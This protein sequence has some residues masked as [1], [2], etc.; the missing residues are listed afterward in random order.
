MQETQ[1]SNTTKAIVW[2]VA[3]LVAIV[4]VC[5]WVGWPFLRIPFTHFLEKQL[6]RTVVIDA[7]FSLHAWG[8]LRLQA[9]HVRMSAPASFQQPYFFDAHGVE[10][11]LRYRDVWQLP[12]GAA[13]RVKAIRAMQLDAHMVR[14]IDGKATWQFDLDDNS[15]TRPFPVIEGLNVRQGQVNVQDAMTGAAVLAKFTTEEGS[16]DASPHAKV[17][18]QG[19]L[20]KVPLRGMLETAGFLPAV[21]QKPDS[22]PVHSS[23]WL[24]YGALS[25][26][27]DGSVYDMFGQPRVKGRLDLVGP[28]LGDVGDLFDITLPRTSAFKVRADI[29]KSSAQ[30][31]VTVP[32]AKIG[33]SALAGKFTY[34]TEGDK[35][36]L[37]GTLTGKK[38][39]LADLAPAFGAPVAEPAS[40]KEH[41]TATSASPPA[42]MFPDTPLDFATYVRMHAEVEVDLDNVD[43]GNAFREPIAPLK[44][45]LSL[46]NNKLSLS[47]IDA[48]TAQGSL[49]GEIFIDAHEVSA[50]QA[51]GAQALVP[52]WGIELA[53]RDIRLEKWL[54]VAPTP[55]QDARTQPDTPGKPSADTPQPYISGLLNGRSRLHGQ[56]RSTRALMQS[57]N[58]ELALLIRQGKV[59]HL[60]I[61]AAGLDIAQ[62]V[63]V[64]IKGDQPLEMQCA[65]MGWK[66]KQGILTPEAALI[67]TKVTTL[68]ATG[69]VDLGQEQLDLT[70]RARPKNFSPLTVRSPIRVQGTFMAPEVSINKAPVAARVAGAALLALINPFAAIL[71]FLDPGTSD[72]ANN[73]DCADTLQQLK[74]QGH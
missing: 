32:A 21:T 20:K 29:E 5:E 34:D 6:E 38:L 28:S 15:P 37:R 30:W 18:L 63:G 8:G 54:K 55:K 36:M 62:A 50:T 45:H 46:L 17:T 27:F 52:D 68:V 56:G 24:N 57:L 59:S 16:A 19:T 72:A 41:A 3:V 40:V 22:P 42:K 2:T 58:G 10:I 61:E 66:A 74:K 48:R 39:Y 53:V 25:L 47:H 69:T 35:P 4:A 23:G 13:Y 64:M 67:D 9:A 43:L 51:A 26:R 11:A 49:A 31:R 12:E 7:P 65:A 70:L 73:A 1:K 44:G 60:L 14:T 71:P 33:R